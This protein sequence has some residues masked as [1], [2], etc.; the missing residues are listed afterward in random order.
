MANERTRARANGVSARRIIIIS[1]Y[2]RRAVN[3]LARGRDREGE[4]SEI[5]VSPRASSGP[6]RPLARV[7]LEI[8]CRVYNGVTPLPC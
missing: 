5:A 6:P 2:E 4:S 8:T 3:V 1:E 7:S